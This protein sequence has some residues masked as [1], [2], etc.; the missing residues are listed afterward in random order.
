MESRRLINRELK[1][2][3]REVE[4]SLLRIAIHAASPPEVGL[5]CVPGLVNGVVPEEVIRWGKLS[6]GI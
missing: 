6:A 2:A 5:K 1:V 4:S 3:L